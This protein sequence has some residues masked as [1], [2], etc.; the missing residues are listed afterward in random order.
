MCCAVLCAQAA[1]VVWGLCECQ[2]LLC[3]LTV[4]L[5][6]LVAAGCWMLMC[7]VWWGPGQ[8]PLLGGAC[9]ACC[10]V[11]IHAVRCLSTDCVC[12]VLCC[13]CMCRCVGPGAAGWPGYRPSRVALHPGC[14]IAYA[15]M[16]DARCGGGSGDGQAPKDSCAFIRQPAWTLAGVAD[17]GRWLRQHAKI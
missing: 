14:C 3:W 6:L 11:G 8:V 5:L 15:A 9:N 10:A 7:C 1:A 17:Q 16:T 12:E 2:R 4:L 13:S